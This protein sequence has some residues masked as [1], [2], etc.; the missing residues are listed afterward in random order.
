MR[1]AR[2][3]AAWFAVLALTLNALWPLLM[4][5]RAKAIPQEICTV[6]GAKTISGA[7]QDMPA[8]PAHHDLLSDCCALCLNGVHAAALAPALPGFALRLEPYAVTFASADAVIWKCP[9]YLPTP[10]RGPPASTI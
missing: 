2:R 8:P 4:Q 3:I 10:S 1:L 9:Y 6:G 7:G 5:A